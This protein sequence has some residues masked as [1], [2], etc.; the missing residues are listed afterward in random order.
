MDAALATSAA[1]AASILLCP[2]T[3]ID[4]IA[5]MEEVAGFLSG[6]WDYANLKGQTGPLVRPS[7]AAQHSSPR[8]GAAASGLQL[9]RL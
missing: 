7:A 4:W 3:E 8:I 2:D 9:T 5:Y 6:D 1:A